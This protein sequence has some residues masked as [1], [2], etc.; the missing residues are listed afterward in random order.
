MRSHSESVSSRW[1]MMIAVRVLANPA[2]DFANQLLTFQINLTCCFVQNQHFGIPQQR[3]SHGDPLPL[4]PRKAV[5]ASPDWR[6]VTVRE[7]LDEFVGVG[8]SRG[9]LDLIRR[10]LRR[11]VADVVKDGIVENQGSLIH[12]R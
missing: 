11:S 8:L 4:A 2:S 1:V 3:P 10:C 5:A 9:R 7:P 12:H 6:V